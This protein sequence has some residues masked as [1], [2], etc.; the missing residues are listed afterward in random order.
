MADR[1]VSSDEVPIPA[2]AGTVWSVLTDLDSYPAWNPF[3]RKAEGRGRQGARWRLELTLNGRSRLTLQ[4]QVTCWEPGRRLTWRG[5]LA[6]PRPFSAHQLVPQ[7]LAGCHDVRIIE[8]RQG[9]SVVQAGIFAGL[10]APGLLPW[11]RT[12]TRARFAEM[13]EALRA[14]VARRIAEAT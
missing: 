5:G 2:R 10:L 11:L 14:E 13:N 7:L 6:L 12:R 9:V 1:R 4:A 3:I 8:T